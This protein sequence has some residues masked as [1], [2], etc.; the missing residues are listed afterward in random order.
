MF[1]PY[2]LVDIDAIAIDLV[3]VENGQH[4]F[5]ISTSGHQGLTA[6]VLRQT[7]VDFLFDHARDDWHLGNDDAR[8]SENDL[9]LRLTARDA[10]LFRAYGW[11]IR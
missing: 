6:C 1:S 4:V 2:D 7:L 11:E 8:F 3:D 10:A 5:N 9:T